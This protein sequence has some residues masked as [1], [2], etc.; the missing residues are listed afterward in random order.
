MKHHRLVCG[1]LLL[2]LAIIVTAATPVAAAVARNGSVVTYAPADAAANTGSTSITVPSSSTLVVMFV[3]GFSGSANFFSGGT[4]TLAGSGMT[5]ATLTTQADAST[6]AMMAAAAFQINPT[7]GSQTFAY[8]FA[9]TATLEVAAVFHFVFFTG[10]HATTPIGS[11]NGNQVGSSGANAG[12]RT[13]A[14]G[15]MVCGFTVIFHAGA[16][17]T[18]TWSGVTHVAGPTANTNGD[19]YADY[20]ETAGTG[21]NITPSDTWTGGD[22]GAVIGL[23]VKQAAGGAAPVLRSTLVGVGP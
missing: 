4:Y 16:A 17:P 6:S 5:V 11:A 19:A 2:C 3:G 14:G 15:D 9:G 23:V 10:T 7:A 22:D 12:A 21:S 13:N 20:A 8:D 18:I 1:F